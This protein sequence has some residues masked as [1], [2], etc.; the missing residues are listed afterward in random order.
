MSSRTSDTAVTVKGR[1][2]ASKSIHAQSR[3]RSELR[4]ALAPDLEVNEM[5][6]EHLC[7]HAAA[8]R[9]AGTAGGRMP[10][11][12]ASG[13]V[14]AQRRGAALKKREAL[15]A[16]AQNSAG[17]WAAPGHPTSTSHDPSASLLP[18][19]RRRMAGATAWASGR[20][21]FLVGLRRSS[22]GG[23]APPLSALVADALRAYLDDAH[24]QR[25][26]SSGKET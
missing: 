12:S 7:R 10:C 20:R 23:S 2:S 26:R 18:L 15:N 21:P 14:G 13:C 16:R 25:P 19:Q 9:R 1:R 24:G 11:A 3:G 5:C 22:A 6:N 17:C 4:C 8:A